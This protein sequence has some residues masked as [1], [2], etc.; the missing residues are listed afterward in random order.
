MWAS[1]FPECDALQQSPSRSTP[2]YHCLGQRDEIHI[3][4]FTYIHIYIYIYIWEYVKHDDSTQWI[5]KPS[6]SNFL[7]TTR[8][9]CKTNPC[10]FYLPVSVV[11]RSHPVR[12]SPRQN[13]PPK[14]GTFRHRTAEQMA[15]PGDFS[16]N[17]PRRGSRT[18]LWSNSWV[19]PRWFNQGSLP[20]L[21]E[22]WNW[23]ITLK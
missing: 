13:P 7:K 12:K 21:P 14:T 23:K 15:G 18:S 16:S 2:S 11:K 9:I 6:K 17:L 20:F 8:Y 5:Q 1:E 10:S 4:V 3:C 19:L 22:S